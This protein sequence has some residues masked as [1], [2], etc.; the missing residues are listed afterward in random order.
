MA[1]AFRFCGSSGNTSHAEIMLKNRFQLFSRRDE[2]RKQ[3]PHEKTMKIRNDI[4]DLSDC[5]FQKFVSSNSRI[6]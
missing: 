5:V 6:D 3:S 1:L 2:T 4:V